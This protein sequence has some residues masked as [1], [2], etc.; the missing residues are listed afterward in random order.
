[1][2][3]A[4]V[5]Q[6]LIL[7]HFLVHRQGMSFFHIWHN[8][9]KIQVQVLS[10]SHCGTLCQ[11]V[12][13]KGPLLMHLRCFFFT[14]LTLDFTI[15]SHSLYRK[16]DL[17]DLIKTLRHSTSPEVTYIK[18]LK[19]DT[20]GDPL[21]ELHG[22]PTQQ[23]LGFLLESVLAQAFGNFLMEFKGEVRQFFFICSKF[24]SAQN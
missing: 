14:R 6:D 24:L 10:S 17:L 22:V 16:W 21:F 7:E 1:M 12:L 11:L 8:A 15:F 23:I 5:L 20:Q 3:C 19:V 2:T 4:K 9:F 18:V 13:Q